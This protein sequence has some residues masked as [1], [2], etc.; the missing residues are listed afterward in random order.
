MILDESLHGTLEDDAEFEAFETG[1]LVEFVLEVPGD[2][3]N[4]R[5]WEFTTAVRRNMTSE[6]RAEIV[7]HEVVNGSHVHVVVDIFA[8]RTKE[9]IGHRLTI[10][11]IDDDRQ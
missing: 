7:D 2:A 10:H 3:A 9:T 5:H 1:G 11:A 4:T 8:E 6:E